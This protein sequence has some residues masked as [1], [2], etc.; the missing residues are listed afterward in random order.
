[1]ISIQIPKF[2]LI[3]VLGVHSGANAIF[4]MTET[5]YLKKYPGCW[6]SRMIFGE[7]SSLG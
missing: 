2:N 5:L 7:K 4:K 3:K 1:M 6:N